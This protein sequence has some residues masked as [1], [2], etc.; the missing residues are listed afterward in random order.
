[1]NQ[2]II[3][4]LQTNKNSYTKKSLIEQLRNAGYDTA[5]ITEAVK[6][7]YG[8]AEVSVRMSNDDVRSDIKYAGFWIR[9]FASLIDSLVVFIAS[10][11]II[12]PLSFFAFDNV[13][14]SSITSVFILFALSLT[15]FIHMTNKYQ[16]TVGKKIFGLKV[17]N[18]E[19]LQKAALGDIINREGISR[20]IMFLFAPIHLFVAIM[21]KKQGVHDM[22][23]NT[24][25]IHKRNK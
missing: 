19:T 17:C 4:Y 24:V 6:S 3:D 11:V 20:V 15:Y 25:V 21:A 12:V 5:E 2:Q 7:V 22:A 16:A 14:F 18:E 1:M 8:D 10:L 23:A 13:F 9:V